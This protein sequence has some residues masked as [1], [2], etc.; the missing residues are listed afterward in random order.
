[1][2]KG[3][4]VPFDGSPNAVEALH[5]AVTLAKALGEKLIVLNVQPSFHTIH[6]KLFFHE[7]DLREY[8]QKLFHEMM[9]TAEPM[10]KSSGVNYEQKLRIGDPRQQIIAEAKDAKIRMIV[11]GSR[12][13]NPIVG[14][15]LGSVS[16]GIVNAAVCPTTIVPLSPL[17]VEVAEQANAS[18]K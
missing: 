4:L 3:L 14:G 2:K 17:E 5:L 12:G 13:M 16:Y 18:A 1:M 10:L 15:V 6:T 8:Q 7:S 11:M 9:E